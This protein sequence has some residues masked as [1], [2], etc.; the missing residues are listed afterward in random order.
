MGDFAY[1]YE[2]DI[3]EENINGEV[4]LMSPSP[5]IHHNMIIGNL[6][7][8]LANYLR[9]KRCRLFFDGVDVHFDEKNTFIPDLMIVCDKDIIKPDGIYGAPDFV[10][11]VLSP[12]SMRR[13]KIEKKAIY[14]KYGVKEYWLVDPLAKSIEVYYLVGGHFELNNIYIVFPDYEWQRLSEEKKAA[15][16]LRFK[17][18]LYDDLTI[19]VREVFENVGK[20]L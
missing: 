5:N 1:A 9:G 7:R 8:I 2:D 11:E 18:S 13:D 10:A 17:L 20:Y 16:E 12:S 6:Y 3:R 14:E 19:D 4:V 15:Q